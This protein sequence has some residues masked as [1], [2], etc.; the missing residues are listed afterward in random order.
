MEIVQ[1][2]DVLTQQLMRLERAV[3][4]SAQAQLAASQPP[5]ALGG[6]AGDLL[7]QITQLLRAFR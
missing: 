6:G 5:R 2:L 3:L 1:R 7:G 4:L